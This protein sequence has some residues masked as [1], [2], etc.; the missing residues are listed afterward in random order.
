MKVRVGGVHLLL[1]EACVMFKEIGALASMLKA[2][3]KMKEEMEKMQARLGEIQVEGDAGAGMV[4]VRVN[5]RMEVVACDISDEAL[6]DRELLEE[7]VRMATNAALDRARQ[8]VAEASGKLVGELG[9]APPGGLPDLSG[10][11]GS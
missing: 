1:P 9:I 5:G 10:L 3:P 7:L 2:L 8:E 6:G 4:K 11:M